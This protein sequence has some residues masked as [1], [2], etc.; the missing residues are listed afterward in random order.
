MQVSS[1][2]SEARSVLYRD[3]YTAW[4]FTR[5]D[6]KT[7][8]IP[9]SFF[10][11]LGGL[12]GSALTTHSNVSG[13]D[14]VRR[15]PLVVL[16][17][18]VVLLPFNIDNQRRADAIVEDKINRPWRPLP[19]KRISPDRAFRFMLF[20]HIAAVGYSLA[21][22]GLRQSLAGIALGWLYNG[23]GGA[24]R[25][26][27][28]KNA[29][30]SLGYVTF[31]MGAISWFG[32][33][34]ATVFTT[35]QIQDLPD[36]EGDA[37]RGRRTVPLVMGSVYCRWSIAILV[38]FWTVAASLFWRTLSLPTVLCAV[39]G[40]TVAWRALNK[41]SMADDKLTFRIWNVWMVSLYSL[42]LASACR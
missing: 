36:M 11:I 12:S 40:T 33:I 4:L 9:K 19:S 24:D 31:S 15:T 17:V 20:C 16:W 1:Y 28:A 32:I 41:T 6:L 14:I 18:W 2:I 37:V 29:V 7:I 3:V 21:V 39:I 30:N 38:P 25:S 42:P 23:L 27:I 22:G 5:S 10:G 8:V 13:W 35:V 34:A 26:C